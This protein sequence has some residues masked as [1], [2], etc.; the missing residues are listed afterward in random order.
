MYKILLDERE[1]SKRG[2]AIRKLLQVLLSAPQSAA[3]RNKSTVGSDTV[4][5]NQN[6]IIGALDGSKP[7]NEYRD[8]R[9][10]SYRAGFRCMY[11][12]EWRPEDAARKKWFLQ[13]ICF[14][15]FRIT[16]RANIPQEILAIHCE[17][18]EPE[19]REHLLYKRGLHLHVTL[20]SQPI[21]HAH[22]ALNNGYLSQVM[23]SIENLSEALELAL[24]MINDQVINNP[25]WD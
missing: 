21:P 1:L 11:F 2:A 3:A 25:D 8:W 9:F 15:L 19:G 17:P 12:E 24:K 5:S 13:Q 4:K 22:F 23:A 10:R 16:S 20:A 6:Y 18:M 7:S 14:S